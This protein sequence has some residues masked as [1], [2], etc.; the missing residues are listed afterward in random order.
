MTFFG[1]A[2]ITAV[3]TA[4]L[5]VFAIV[6]AWYARKAFLKQSQEVRAI[7]EQVSDQKN[8]TGQQAE[9]IQIQSGQLEALREQLEDQRQANARQAEVFDL[10]ASE[11]RE[12][13]E[14]RKQDADERKRAQ[15][16]EVT[17]W[18]ALTSG[19]T[20]AAIIRNASELPVLDVRTF[21]HYVAEKW[22]AGDWDPQML[23]G[24]VERIRVLPPHQDRQVAIP[25]NIWSQMTEVSDN[26]YV[27]SI[28]FTDA[29][30]NRWE[31]D[32]RGALN[33]RS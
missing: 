25:E 29:A 12:S 4:V 11:L 28:E 1:M 10:Q 30:G 31:R 19:K 15:A 18:F 14:E 8:L 17:A 33:P 23:G 13:L 7:E 32:P 16:E 5:A 27:V 24:P 9:L 22:Q 26:N 2:L 20:F 21:F 3:A 6:T